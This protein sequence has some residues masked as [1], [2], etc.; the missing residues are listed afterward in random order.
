MTKFSLGRDMFTLIRHVR[1]ETSVGVNTPKKTGTTIRFHM[2]YLLRKYEE[3]IYLLNDS[4]F[5]IN[6][7]IHN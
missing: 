7:K 1:Q 2:K 3:T 5:S 6:R 4:I